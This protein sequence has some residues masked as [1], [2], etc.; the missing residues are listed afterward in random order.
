M[1]N[2]FGWTMKLKNVRSK[3]LEFD[4]RCKE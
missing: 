3:D 1:D 4:K 2:S